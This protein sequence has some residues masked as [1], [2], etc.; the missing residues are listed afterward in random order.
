MIEA[1][2][3]K[4]S[5][6]GGAVKK[7]VLYF[8]LVLFTIFPL[9]RL[10]FLLMTVGANNPNNDEVIIYTLI[11]KILDGPYY[12]LDFIRDTF[13]T[14]HS[15]V[16]PIF[17][18]YLVARYAEGNI[19]F[20]LGIGLFL[21]S[22][23]TIFLYLALSLRLQSAAR[24]LLLPMLSFMVFSPSQISVYE[25]DFPAL[26]TGFCQVGLVLG[27]WAL[28]RFPD[29]WFGISLAGLGMVMACWSTGSGLGTVPVFFAVLFLSRSKR[30]LNYFLLL[31]FAG[32]CVWPYVNALWINPIPGTARNEL[33]QIRPSLLLYLVGL[34]FSQGFLLE[35][36]WWRG[37]LG[38]TMLA[39]NLCF[40]VVQRKAFF[41][42][43][44]PALALLLFSFC[45][46]GQ[47]LIFRGSIGAWYGGSTMLFWIALVGMGMV[48][49]L[50]S[51]REN[52]AL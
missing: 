16:F 40:L 26:Q 19:Y 18:Q 20:L 36:Q 13:T 43:C 46:M 7:T 9:A 33:S 42:A 21:A 15:G 10:A 52:F 32:I 38:F 30:V 29:R 1:P 17:T 27:I 12:W 5:L 48:Y 49:A 28:L 25:Y 37:F 35:T 8:G 51:R 47:I 45:F 11:G 4:Q 44:I 14:S 6:S 2:Q 34:P 3:T 41:D 50:N 22:V 24:F 39:L 31:V 23:K